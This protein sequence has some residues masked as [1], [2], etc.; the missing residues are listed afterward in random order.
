MFFLKGF[1]EKKTFF[2][3]SVAKAPLSR[4]HLLIKFTFKKVFKQ[5]KRIQNGSIVLDFDT[6]RK[7]YS[8]KNFT[9]TFKFVTTFKYETVLVT[10]IF[11]HIPKKQPL[12]DSVHQ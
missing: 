4:Q 10:I 6:L 1:N 7:N 2:V 11:M 5:Y 9:T 12:L 8:V 3:T